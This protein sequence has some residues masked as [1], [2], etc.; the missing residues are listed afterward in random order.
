MAVLL[1]Q[2]TKQADQPRIVLDDEQMHRRSAYPFDHGTT[3]TLPAVPIGPVG[4][5]LAFGRP[6]PP[7]P[8]N[9]SWTCT[10]EPVLTSAAVAGACVW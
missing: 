10:F 6:P 7:L 2:A 8:S 9:W 5:E 3:V 1:E 4:A